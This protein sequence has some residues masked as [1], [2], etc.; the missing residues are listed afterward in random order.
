MDRHQYK[1]WLLVGALAVGALL[2]VLLPYVRTQMMGVFETIGSLMQAHP[3][4]GSLLFVAFAIISATAAFFSSTVLVPAAV[5]AWGERITFGLLLAGWLLGAVAAYFVGKYWGRKAVGFFTSLERLD[6]YQKRIAGRLT[7]FSV[8]FFRFVLPSEIPS[9]LL[10]LLRYDFAKYLAVTVLTEAPFA[11]AA[12]Y[13]GASLLSGRYLIFFAVVIGV[14]A[15]LA[16]LA[17]LWQRR[18]KSRDS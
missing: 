9:Y 8:L 10:G 17:Y 3:L 1:T 7:F 13:A 6:Y 14:L 16:L 12:V 4:L 18:V 5:A 15:M 2:V 11:F